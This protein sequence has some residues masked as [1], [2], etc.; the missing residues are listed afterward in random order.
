MTVTP[1]AFKA[2]KAQFRKDSRKESDS[3]LAPMDIGSIK[4]DKASKAFKKL[5][6]KDRDYLLKHDGCFYCRKA[7]AGHKAAECPD[8]KKP[9]N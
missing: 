4:V 8:K 6:A 3:G 9:S 1:H 5:S 2:H 7:N